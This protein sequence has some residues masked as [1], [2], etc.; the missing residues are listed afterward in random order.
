M[1]D[2]TIHSQTKATSPRGILS[3]FRDITYLR[4]IILTAIFLVLFDNFLFFKNVLEVY[5]ISLQNIG[6][7]SSLV[8][9]F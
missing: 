2:S 6:F 1:A 7:L 5:P 9:S 3:R 4:L 8:V